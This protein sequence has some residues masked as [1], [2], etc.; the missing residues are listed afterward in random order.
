MAE[1]KILIYSNTVDFADRVRTLLAA[2]EAMIPDKIINSE[3]FKGYAE[4]A[5]KKAVPLWK[6]ILDGVDDAKIELL[7]S[8]VVLKTAILSAPFVKSQR[9][10]VIQTTHDKV[11]YFENNYD[12][13]IEGL[14]ERLSMLL[15]ELNEETTMRCNSFF[16]ITNP[17][18]RYEGAGFDLK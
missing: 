2:D 3:D 13:L 15:M 5:I 18:I 11:E 16:G 9:V 6:E 7:K 17:N 14:A 4:T 12:L 10:K 1:T 8:C